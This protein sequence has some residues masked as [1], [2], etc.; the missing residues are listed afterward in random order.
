MPIYFKRAHSAFLCLILVMLCAVLPAQAATPFAGLSPAEVA[1]LQKGEVV[2]KEE[3]QHTGDN[4]KNVRKTV[5]ARMIIERPVEAVWRVISDQPLMFSKDPRVKSVKVV[6]KLST[7]EELINYQIKLGRMLP[8]FDY[9]TRV[10]Y[11]KPTYAVFKRESGDFK[12][13]RSEFF[14]LPVNGGKHTYVTYSMYVDVGFFI[15]KFVTRAIIKGDIP[16]IAEN[17][18]KVVYQKNP[19]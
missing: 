19:Q 6:K 7:A 11:R 5:V 17:V 3:K 8:D 14:L 12:D 4:E 15:P 16:E 18:R 2:I 1:T 10:N 9:T 13:F